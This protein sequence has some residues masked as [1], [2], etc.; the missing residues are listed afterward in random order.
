[1]NIRMILYNCGRMTALAALLFIPCVI[2]S[3]IYADGCAR[4]FLLPALLMALCGFLLTLVRPKNRT[5]YA[6]EGFVTATLM[7]LLFS[8]FGA[9][10]FVLSG[11]IPAF[12]DAFFETVSGFTTT[13]SS[14]LPDVEALSK[15][16]LFWRSLTH[17]VGGMGV[18]ALAIALLPSDSE[19]ASSDTSAM[20]ILKAETPGPTF[21]KLVAKLRRNVRILYAMYA[22]LTLVEMIFL[23]AGGMSVFDTLVN[24]FGTAGTGG[25][26]IYNLSIGYYDNVYFETVIGVFMLLFGVNFNIYF[27][28]LTGNFVKILKSEELRWYFGIVAVSVAAITLNILP[29]Y[30]SVGMSLRYAFFQVSS[31]ITTTGYATADFN[32]WPTLSKCILV[33]LM[34]CGACVSS[35]AGGLKVARVIILVKTAFRNIRA[36]VNPREVRVIRCDGETVDLTVVHSVTAYFT[37]YMMIL[38]FSAVLISLDGKDV[39]STVTSVI[40]CLNNIGPGLDLVGPRGNFSEFSV[41]SK[42]VLCF[43]ML[44]GRLEIYPLLI[45]LSP[46][47]WKRSV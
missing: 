15:S 19:A 2:V 1:M 45:T 42:L 40:A 4:A 16:V 25:F 21:G 34:F 36:Q 31:I 41:L 22:G 30:R 27:F 10:P 37:I 32:L 47:V 39:T 14:I 11:E 35:T 3:L 28:L 29:L 5:T 23:L 7:W 13:G 20:H 8:L 33:L 17:W 12:V 26:G 38:F 18:L 46:S 43:D 24:S 44:A 9:L 6:R